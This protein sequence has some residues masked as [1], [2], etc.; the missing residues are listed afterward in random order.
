MLTE[1]SKLSTICCFF[2]ETLFWNFGKVESRFLSKIEI[3]DKAGFQKQLNG[4]RKICSQSI[5]MIT[6]DILTRV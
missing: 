4:N 1:K 6:A 2:F 5:S 3:F